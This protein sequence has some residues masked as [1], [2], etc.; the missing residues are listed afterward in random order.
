MANNLI[1]IIIIISSSSSRSSSSRR[2]SKSSSSS[3]SGMSF[4]FMSFIYNALKVVFWKG[5]MSE[6]NQFVSEL[7]IWMKMDLALNN[8]QRLICHKP[9]T[10]NNQSAF[11]IWLLFEGIP[12][13]GA[14]R[15]PDQAPFPV[16]VLCPLCKDLE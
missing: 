1:I 14:H 4:S 10:T 6:P 13:G 7:F 15:C 12:G 9:Q 16:A 11:I 3:S 2:R 5:F 8:L